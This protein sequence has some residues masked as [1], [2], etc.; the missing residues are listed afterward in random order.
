VRLEEATALCEARFLRPVSVVRLDGD[1]DAT[2]RVE[3][4][5]GCRYALKLS[6]GDARRT[7]LRLERAALRRLEAVDFPGVPRLVRSRAGR[8][9]ERAARPEGD[10]EARLLTWVDGVCLAAV[11]PVPAGILVELGF[12]L[13]SLDQALG[14]IEP[15]GEL[16][17]A[18]DMAR[19]AE[20]RREIDD[21][22]T[23][24]ALVT[25]AVDRYLARRRE[26]APRVP[27]SLVH[28]DANDR[29]R[30]AGPRPRPQRR[31]RPHQRTDPADLPALDVEG[32][33]RRLRP[34]EGEGPDVGRREP[35]D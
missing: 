32:R 5:S 16:Y 23:D 3:D 11:K 19:L 29:K 22:P 14:P 6:S 20:L 13:G 21:L 34:A 27:R 26:L 12:Y 15:S 33:N 9:S 31:R 8:L 30:Q 17:L 25:T 28:Y 24:R 4:A 10:L 2:Y 18:W 35:G 1:Q 7:A